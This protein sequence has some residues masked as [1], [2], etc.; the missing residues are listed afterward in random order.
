MVRRIAAGARGGLVGVGPAAQPTD[1]VKPLVT[2]VRGGVHHYSESVREMGWAMARN[3]GIMAPAPDEVLAV[4][5][6]A[7][8]VLC[9]RL[10]GTPQETV[11]RVVYEVTAELVATISDPGRLATMLRLRAAAR[12]A[13]AAGQL[14][15]IRSRTAVPAPR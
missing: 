1:V 2:A 10:P 11:E 4:M 15:P 14:T 9:A 7:V 6:A 12:L 3:A 13:A 5:A 8:D